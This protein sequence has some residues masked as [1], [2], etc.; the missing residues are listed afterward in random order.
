[1]KKKVWIGI[2]DL[3]M[4]SLREF[5]SQKCDIILKYL[6]D[7]IRQLKAQGEVPQDL[8]INDHADGPGG[9]SGIEFVQGNDEGESES[10]DSDSEDDSQDETT[11]NFNFQQK[12]KV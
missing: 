3:V 12:K 4:C 9:V 2:G 5:Q 11:P 1:M 6:P 10:S 8:E 7:E